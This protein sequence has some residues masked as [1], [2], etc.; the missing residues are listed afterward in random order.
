MH[1]TRRLPPS[2]Q[3]GKDRRREVSVAL[4]VP[5]VEIHEVY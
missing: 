2:G 5:G 3:M 4:I 1:L